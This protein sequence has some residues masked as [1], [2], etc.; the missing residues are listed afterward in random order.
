M[1]DVAV[2]GAG[3]AGA[4]AAYHAARAGA[5]VAVLE[6]A[7]PPRYKTCG[8]GVV[9][10]ARQALPLAI[11][12]VAESE[13]H[14]A[15]MDFSE[16]GVSFTLRRPRPVVTMTMRA[17]LDA[18]LLDA[19][20]GQG[21]RVFHPCLVQ[22]LTPRADEVLLETVR[23]PVRA[24][25]VI[26][27]D[28]A[29]GAT[30]RAAGWREPAGGIPALEWELRVPPRVRARWNGL[31]AFDCGFIPDG[32]AWVFPK[33]G[34]LSVGVV[35]TRRGRAGLRADLDRYLRHVGLDGYEEA[36]RHGF[37]IPVRPRREG[38]ARARV[39]LAGDAAGLADPVTCEGLSHAALSGRL[40][41]RAIASDAPDPERVAQSYEAALRAEV[42]AELEAARGM[43]RLLWRPSWLRRVVMRAQGHRLCEALT[44]VM[45]GRRT[46][47][48]RWSRLGS[49]GSY[50]SGSVWHAGGPARLE[51]RHGP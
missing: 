25:F 36:E 13:C 49:P 38:F 21:A 45:L 37:V 20:C 10:R 32:Y 7:P 39:L 4:V 42:L 40:A 6:R 41:A 51:R 18:H 3:P 5:R 48:E 22:A 11:D 50:M 1:V 44:D 8:G 46:Y 30:A 16:A 12:A 19:A 2:V 9:W 17:R 23:G 28:G 31:A 24:R 15:R 43:A 33:R 29:T 47:R 26:A 14:A 27:A 35:A 34:H